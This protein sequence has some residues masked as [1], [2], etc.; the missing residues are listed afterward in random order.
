MLTLAQAD[1]LT[2]VLSMIFVLMMFGTFTGALFLKK[3]QKELAIITGI[4]AA[5]LLIV[6]GIAL[7]SP[8]IFPI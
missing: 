3:Y 5:L 1:V 4:M 6:M 7:A 2:A 8:F